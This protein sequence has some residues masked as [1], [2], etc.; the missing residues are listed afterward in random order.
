MANLTPLPPLDEDVN[1]D[2]D[3][4]REI[5][6]YAEGVE[7][8]SQVQTLDSPRLATFPRALSS[9]GASTSMGDAGPSTSGVA[10]RD[11]GPHYVCEDWVSRISIEKMVFVAHEYRL[12]GLARWPKP[13][14]RLHLPPISFMTISKTILKAGVF[15]PL[16]PFIDQVL[17]FFDI[18]SFQLTPN[19]YR[20]IMAF[21]IA[22]L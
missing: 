13:D 12:R 2:N 19:S 18:V 17:Q 14:E 7:G 3:L 5:E 8:D 6:N 11:L 22:F 15:L 21:Y 1:S 16:H 9:R 4:I 20:I 10:S